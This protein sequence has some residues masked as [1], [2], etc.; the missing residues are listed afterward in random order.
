MGAMKPG[1]G[2]KK[3]SSFEG[4]VANML[5]NTLKP[6]KFIRTQ[7]SGAR[8]GGKNFETLGQMFGEEALKLFVGDV[9]PVNE[10]ESGVKFAFSIE[11]KFY[12]TPDNFVSIMSG[13]ANIYKWMQESVDDAIKINK[14]PMTVFKWNHSP[15][16]ASIPSN[17]LS[18][19]RLLVSRCEIL[20]KAQNLSFYNFEDLLQITG[21]WYE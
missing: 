15:I 14:I 1:A 7:G 19:S 16:F 11:T 9:V 12:K 18:E 6:L 8:V 4:K 2:K 17:R 21:F 5:S 10:K 20:Y 3:G 13:T